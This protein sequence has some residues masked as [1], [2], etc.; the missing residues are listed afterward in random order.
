M[1]DVDR[2]IDACVTS[3]Q[4]ACGA[5]DALHVWHHLQLKYTCSEV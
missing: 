1:R 4:P 3:K 2:P 5:N